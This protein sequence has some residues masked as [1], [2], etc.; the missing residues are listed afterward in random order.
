MWFDHFTSA[1]KKVLAIV[2]SFVLLLSVVFAGVSYFNGD[3]DSE[4]LMADSKPPTFDISFENSDLL[5]SIQG[6]CTLPGYL[7]TDG[8]RSRF[9][10]SGDS[11]D[12]KSGI[13]MY[14]AAEDMSLESIIDSIEPVAGNKVMFLAYN[15][16]ANGSNADDNLFSIYPAIGASD[17]VIDIESPS[18]YIVPA[19]QGFALISCMNS[20]IFGVKN[21]LHAGAGDPAN[22]DDIAND[23]LLFAASDLLNLSG[24]DVKSLWVQSAVRDEEGVLIDNSFDRFRK[25]EDL[26]AAIELGDHHM[27]WV[28][29][30]ES[31][32]SLRAA[33]TA[34]QAEC[35]AMDGYEWSDGMCRVHVITE[36]EC[37]AM[38]G[39]VWTAGVCR[40]LMPIEGAV[41]TTDSGVAGN[42]DA[43]MDCRIQLD[44][45]PGQS[46][47]GD[48]CICPAGNE[49]VSAACVPVCA[50]GEVRDYSG[51]GCVDVSEECD[52]SGGG[53]DAIECRS[54]SFQSADRALVLRF[55]SVIGDL[56]QGIEW[57]GSDRMNEE[58]FQSFI[59]EANSL[60]D[61]FDTYY[62]SFDRD[63]RDDLNLLDEEL[64]LILDAAEALIEDSN[65]GDSDHSGGGN[66]NSGSGGNNGDSADSVCSS[67]N[68]NDLNFVVEYS[69]ADENGSLAGLKLDENDKLIR[70]REYRVSIEDFNDQ[71]KDCFVGWGINSSLNFN[72]YN[73]GKFDNSS[74]SGRFKVLSKLIFKLDGV[75][76]QSDNDSSN[77]AVVGLYLWNDFNNENFKF[78]N[79]ESVNPLFYKSF[80]VVSDVCQAVEV[81]FKGDSVE[82]DVIVDLS[83]DG[84]YRGDL[85]VSFNRH[86]VSSED[87]TLVKNESSV[88]KDIKI[89]DDAWNASSIGTVRFE[90]CKIPLSLNVVNKNLNEARNAWNFEVS[91]ISNSSRPIDKIT[92]TKLY[93]LQKVWVPM[94]H[95]GFVHIISHYKD[96]WGSDVFSQIVNLKSNSFYRISAYSSSKNHPVFYNVDNLTSNIC[97]YLKKDDYAI[98]FERL[99][100]GTDMQTVAAARDYKSVT[101]FKCCDPGDSGS[102]CIKNHMVYAGT[103]P[104]TN[105]PD[106]APVCDGA[107]DGDGCGFVEPSSL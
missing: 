10:L 92:W 20:K 56:E 40:A 81:S 21:E 95:D 9:S 52:A 73:D 82:T 11:V 49:M 34:S 66:N 87:F 75:D 43:N 39:R 69:N 100:L 93:A 4:N 53:L 17:Q 62:D 18:E 23:W 88:R 61:Y 65:G 102:H 26:D 15:P 105:L 60:R 79:E 30:A 51:G 38:D 63:V 31:V 57:F 13:F 80:N 37:D 45:L 2:V 48:V 91:D 12:L 35:A 25:V 83:F 94:T 14:H 16:L 97:D 58:D 89:R 27:V 46:R 70:G 90:N 29:V 6:A 86:V 5:G 28:E 85:D 78:D 1:K 41:C 50:V 33:G 24:F 32:A 71:Y 76:S 77:I 103:Y 67:L 44:C 54:R 107:G 99:A 98:V 74:K 72:I 3:G 104:S 106:D 7:F 96:I 55:I 47:V 19:N 42:L 36:A 64:V 101:Y 59:D 8:M 22:V 84:S 68:V